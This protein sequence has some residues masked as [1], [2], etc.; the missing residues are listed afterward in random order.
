MGDA[1][2]FCDGRASGDNDPGMPK[3]VP[4]P[5]IFVSKTHD[6]LH[7]LI[8]IDTKGAEVNNGVFRENI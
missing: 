1:R 6:Y 7:V 4:A 3:M 5:R 2:G 8:F